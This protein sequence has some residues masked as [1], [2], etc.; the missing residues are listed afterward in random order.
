MDS[1][2]P[3]LAELETFASDR[4]VLR[5]WD[6]ADPAPTL[7]EVTLSF[8][9]GGVS[10]RS[11]CNL[12]RASV[13][14]GDLAGEFTLG[15][16]MGTRRACPDDESAVEARYLRQLAAA[17]KLG[18]LAGR[19]ALTYSNEDGSSGVMLFEQQAD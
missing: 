11:G 18:L 16:I 2:A 4:W 9:D 7:P 13:T 17:S 8:A 14:E 15:P 10:G 6:L 1:A 12:Y 19:L 5:T 3:T